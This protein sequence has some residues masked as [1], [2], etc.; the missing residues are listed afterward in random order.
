MAQFNLGIAIELA[1][2]S[3]M[4]SAEGPDWEKKSHSLS[5]LYDDLSERGYDLSACFQAAWDKADVPLSEIAF[6]ETDCPLPPAEHELNE[7]KPEDLRSLLERFD[8]VMKLWQKRY[9]FID[10]GGPSYFIGP[11]S[12][13]I[14][15]HFVNG[16]CDLAQSSR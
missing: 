9:D 11:D 7:D 3:V 10:D 15:Y 8:K 12:F 6:R 4:T 2:K 1:M 14:W 5:G 16:F 13:P